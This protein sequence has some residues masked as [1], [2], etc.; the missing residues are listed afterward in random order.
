MAL[1]IFIGGHISNYAT[2]DSHMQV[3]NESAIR[4]NRI[5]LSPPYLSLNR[6]FPTDF[7]NSAPAL[8]QYSYQGE[9]SIFY[10]IWV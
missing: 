7:I 6:Y 2:W 10:S 4:Y 3:M 5:M 8:S 1:G 9:Y